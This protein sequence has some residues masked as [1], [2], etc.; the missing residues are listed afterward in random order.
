MLRMEKII[1]NVAICA[2][3]SQYIHSALA[4]W[5]LLAGINAYGDT[6]KIN[7][8]ILEGTINESDEAVLQRIEAL[9]P[10]VVSFCTYIWNVT[11][12]LRLTKELKKRFPKLKLILGGPEVG[13]CAEK[14][15][16]ENPEIDF[17]LSGE[18]EYPYPMLLMELL[19]DVPQYKTVPGI[20]FKTQKGTYFISEPYLPKEDPVSPYCDAYFE[21]LNGRLAY[22]ETSRGCPYSCAFCLSGRCGGARFFDIEEAKK[23]M[24]NLANSG[25]KTIKLVDR[26][27]NADKKRAYTLFSFIISEYGKRIPAGVCFHFEIAGDILDD[28]M[29]SLLNSAPKGAIQLEIGLQSFNEETLAAVTRKTNIK[30]LTENI[31][32]LLLPR[33]IHVHIDLIAGL[34]YEGLESFKESFNTAYALK[35]DMLQFGFLKLLHGAPMRENAERYPCVY[36]KEPP[37]EVQETPWLSKEEFHLLK[38]AESVFDKLYNS[39]R[40]LR[41][42]AYAME[43]IEIKPFDL[44]LQFAQY[45]STVVEC[46]EH[47]MP[48]DTYTNFLFAFL[49]GFS[50][51]DSEILRDVMIC[52][53]FATNSS[54]ILPQ[55]LK[56][57][58]ANLKKVKQYV[59]A[60]IPF[61]LPKHGKRSIA[62]L[63]GQK[64]VVYADYTELPNPVTREYDLHF[65]PFSSFTTS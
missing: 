46:P 13:Y 16:M 52:D 17:I 9:Q 12:V 36:S 24:V 49:S 45:L 35:P 62:I 41:T 25:A 18:G 42:I 14:V 65:M 33:N 38:Q 63:Y 1:M 26:T 58:D 19:K 57:K 20:C 32:K 43:T 27:F 6:N 56:R 23:N 22:L 7:A 5:C 31:T 2:L 51:V 15:L 3:N 54:N 48:L 39:G 40:F 4:P 30:R 8:S 37:Y 21:Q 55:N 59:N 28:A 44:F 10:D 29:I 53:R 64:A 60:N 11:M 61:K 34:P 47:S 50:K